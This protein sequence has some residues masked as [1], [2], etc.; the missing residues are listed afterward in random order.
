MQNDL[1]QKAQAGRKKALMFRQLK[2]GF[3]FDTGRVHRLPE[4]K[5]NDVVALFDS[6]Q[7]HF[8]RTTPNRELQSA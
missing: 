3:G 4:L 5:P 6:T 2:E 7:W 1:I 8:S